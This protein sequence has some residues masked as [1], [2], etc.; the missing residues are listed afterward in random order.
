MKKAT[1][2]KAAVAGGTLAALLGVGAAMLSEGTV[3]EWEGEVRRPYQDVGGIW[4][5]CYG[6]TNDIDITR[7]YTHVEC[8]DSLRDELV[9]H[10]KGVLACTPEVA[11]LSDGEKAARVSLA[12][13][14]GVGNYCASTVARLTRSGDREGAC[15]AITMWD[16]VKGKPQK[17]LTRRR[18]AESEMCLAGAYA[19]AD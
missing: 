7:E 5:V 3:A 17:G 14:I 18:A 4:T 2:I 1:G 6:D 11:Y 15:K 19:N 10:A 16:K 9:K 12:Y 8:L 13:N